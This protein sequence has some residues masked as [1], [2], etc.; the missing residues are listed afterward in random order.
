MNKA[1]KM[2]HSA[3][4][5]YAKPGSFPA[6]KRANGL[7]RFKHVHFPSICSQL[8]PEGSDSYQAFPSERYSAAEGQLSKILPHGSL[9]RG[10]ACPPS[11]SGRAAVHA[12]PTASACSHSWAARS[13]Q[14]AAGLGA[15]PVHLVGQAREARNVA[16]LCMRRW[17]TLLGQQAMRCAYGC[18]RCVG[19]SA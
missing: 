5:V 17:Q 19:M 10:V 16:A 18:L 11:C 12:L 15:Q 14:Q 1:A 7:P 4:R 9:M 8:R 2:M 6:L 13:R 3:V